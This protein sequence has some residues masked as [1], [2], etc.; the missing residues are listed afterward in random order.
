MAPQSFILSNTEVNVSDR[1]W[2]FNKLVGSDFQRNAL[3]I[4]K[5]LQKLFIFQYNFLFTYKYVWVHRFC[6]SFV[7]IFKA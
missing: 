5:S 6:F 4:V 7:I 3:L 1:D 2:A